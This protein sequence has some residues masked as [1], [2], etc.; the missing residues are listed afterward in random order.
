MAFDEL[1]F[2]CFSYMVFTLMKSTIYLASK[3]YKRIYLYQC[4]L[5]ISISNCSRRDN[6]FVNSLQKIN[7]NVVIQT[8][9]FA[10]HYILVNH[11]KWFKFIK[12]PGFW[13]SSCY[14]RWKFSSL[15]LNVL[16]T[17]QPHAFSHNSFNS[18]I[19]LH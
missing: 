8:L 18:H 3:Q 12:I 2:H 10:S 7:K 11:K 16:L 13:I 15:A 6:G 19:P 4:L 1:P 14:K 9:L 5:C 17:V